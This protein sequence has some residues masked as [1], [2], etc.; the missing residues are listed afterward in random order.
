[1]CKRLS[2]P[3]DGDLDVRLLCSLGVDSSPR[4]LWRL[5]LLDVDVEPVDWIAALVHRWFPQQHQRVATHLSELQV[6]RGSCGP[7]Q[8]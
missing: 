5:R 7:K 8:K 6:V 1:M 2:Q 4:L 3:D